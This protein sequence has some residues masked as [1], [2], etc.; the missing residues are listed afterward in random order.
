MLEFIERAWQYLYILICPLVPFE[1]GWPGQDSH[2]S[3]CRLGEY[4]RLH[5]PLGTERSKY[6]PLN[7]LS[8]EASR[9]EV[10]TYRVLLRQEKNCLTRKI[11]AVVSQQTQCW[12]MVSVHLGTELR[13]RTHA[14]VQGIRCWKQGRSRRP[15]ERCLTGGCDT[16]EAIARLLL[17]RGHH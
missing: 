17:Q 9:E 2:S 5:W 7:A 6:A 15:A 10:L 11:A 3:Y 16:V 14:M 1:P 4:K 12:L 13:G 8:V